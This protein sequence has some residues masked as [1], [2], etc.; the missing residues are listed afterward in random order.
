LFTDT[1]F[2]NACSRLSLMVGQR[3]ITALLAKLYAEQLIAVKVE[4][5]KELPLQMPDSIPDL[6]LSYRKNGFKAPSLQDGF[7]FLQINTN[8]QY[9]AIMNELAVIRT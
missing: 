9:C 1:E 5:M 2:F 4:G 3:N 8:G 6:M 7:H